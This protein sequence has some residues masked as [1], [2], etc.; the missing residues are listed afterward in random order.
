MLS[1]KQKNQIIIITRITH[2]KKE[3]RERIIKLEHTTETNIKN[4]KPLLVFSAETLFA[5]P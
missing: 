2:K 3:K 5:A 4:W 1:L